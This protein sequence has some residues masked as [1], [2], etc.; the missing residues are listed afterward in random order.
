MASRPVAAVAVVVATV[1]LLAGCGGQDAQH[2]DGSAADG[3]SSGTPGVR[4]A[5][6]SEAERVAAIQ[7]C[8]QVIT[9]AGVMVRDYNTFMKR[10]NDTQDYGRIGNEDRWARETLTTGADVVHKAITPA[11]PADLVED[12]EAFVT[13]SEKLAEGIGQRQ[14]KGL[15]RVGGDWDKRRTAVLDRCSEYLPTE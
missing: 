2:P 9:S 1:L 15:N 12:V 8:R 3:S 14:R 6:R 7:V 10:L 5:E 13:A 4:S 11:T